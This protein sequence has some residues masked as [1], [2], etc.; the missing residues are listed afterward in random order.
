MPTTTVSV[1][2][3]PL[4]IGFLVREGSLE[5]LVEASG[6]NTLLIGGMYNPIL[7]ISGNNELPESLVRLF[8]LDILYPV[9]KT[10]EINVFLEQHKNLRTTHN[11]SNNFFYEEWKVKGKR[12][13]Y[14]DVIN[15]IEFYWETEFKHRSRKFKSEFCLIRWAEDDPLHNLLCLNF[16]HYPKKYDLVEDYEEAFLNGLRARELSIE[17]EGIVDVPEGKVIVPINTTALELEGYGGTFKGNGAYFGDENN[18][19]DL[20]SYWNLRAAGLLVDFIPLGSIKR[21]EKRTRGLFTRLDKMPSFPAH[22]EDWITI[23]FHPD[24]KDKV[25]GLINEF[26]TDKEKRFSTND[27]VIWNGLNIK[28]AGFYFNWQQSLASVEDFHGRPT[29]IVDLRGKPPIIENA[30]EAFEQRL[31]ASIDAYHEPSLN[32]HTLKPPF[33]PDL[34]DFFADKIGVYPW[35]LRV[36]KDGIGVTIN[37]S[38]HSLSLY[39]LAHQK[40]IHKLFEYSGVHAEIRTPGLVADQ[41]IHKLGGIEGG[42]FFKL[43]GVR[44]LIQNLKPDESVSKGE[45]T[46]TIW[47]EGIFQRNQGPYSNPER[48][49]EEL[50]KQDFF[51]AGLELVCEQCTLKNWLPLKALDDLWLCTYCGKENQT[52]LHLKN[53]GDWRFRK[54]GL[55]AKDNN[56]EGAIPVILT[57][58]YFYQKLDGVLSNFIYSTALNLK[59]NTQTCESDLSILH[60]GRRDLIEMGIAECKSRGGNIEEQDIENLVMIRE[61]VEH[62]GISCILIFS[63]TADEFRPDELERFKEW[64]SRDIPMILLLNNDLDPF[65][66]YNYLRDEQLPHKYPHSLKELAANS[67]HSYLK[68]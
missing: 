26:P 53:R 14:L 27:E 35:S 11:H 37:A 59:V 1:R 47:N 64:S 31:V 40:L 39:P 9:A 62:K 8:N 36:E 7:P 51:R 38:A 56:Q 54:S 32:L 61:Q 55:L 19:Q 20:V 28:A 13:I 21:L 57:L 4:R 67:V 30:K 12:P 52:S 41:L 65:D 46:K 34:N 42:H 5:D 17:K 66:P 63:K 23:Y 60:Y 18:F 45:A 10:P 6:L 33:I 22:I 48:A 58:K 2:Y 68:G 44:K 3:R 16:G 25:H 50:L 49:F 24:N 29:V 43:I 15:A